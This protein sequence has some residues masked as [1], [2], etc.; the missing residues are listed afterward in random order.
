MSIYA[1]QNLTRRSIFQKI[2]KIFPKRDFIVELQNL[3]AK[4]ENDV[5][6]I[7]PHDV[8][9]LK[10]KYKIKENDFTAEKK[11]LLDKY[12]SF[13]FR[14]KSL[15]Q[16]EKDVLYH[17]CHIL[18]VND[19]YLTYQIQEEGKHIY[20]LKVQDVLSDDKLTDSEREELSALR[21]EFNLSDS[22]GQTIYSDEC[23]QKIQMYI[24]TLIAKRRM[25]PEEEKTLDDMISDLGIEAHFTSG[26]QELRHFWDI[27]NADLPV[28]DSPINLQ[29]N[30][31]L[32]YLAPIEWYEERTRTTS[33]SYIG[34]TS[35]FRITKGVSL[36]AGTIAPSRNT[37]EYMKLIDSGDVYFT[38]KRILFVGRSS[39]K[40]IPLSKVLYIT[41]FSDGIE[42]GKATGK[43]PFFKCSDSETMGLYLARLLKDC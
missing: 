39:N 1:I 36:R 18:N 6:S 12:I 35:N 21:N 23:R 37:E 24:N 38:N 4:N 27:E 29:K 28:L 41:P 2:F 22:T 5:L 40:T 10:T 42:I 7:A 8:E 31:H 11:S 30:E 32:Y 17:L 9:V 19:E 13:C 25:S 26:L 16:E 34:L 3:L 14:D 33:V 43:K 20:R 15:S